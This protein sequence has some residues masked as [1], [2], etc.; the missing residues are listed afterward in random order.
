L[1]ADKLRAFA[2]IAVTLSA[3]LILAACSKG[4]HA[5]PKSSPEPGLSRIAA[6]QEPVKLERDMMGTKV[7]IQVSGVPREQALPAINRAFEKIAELESWAHPKHKDS[8]VWNITES[9]GKKPVAVHPGIMEILQTA[10]QVSEASGGAFDITFAAAGR[11]WD[12]KHPDAVPPDPQLLAQAVRKVDYRKLKLDEQH[13]TA[14]LTEEGMEIGLGAIAK[15]WAAD[16]AADSLKAEGFRSGIVDAGGDMVV[17]GGKGQKPWTVEINHPRKPH[18][19]LYAT[20]RPERP[21]AIVTSGD[22]ERY[23]IKNDIRYHHILDPKTGDSARLCQSVTV[24][25][26]NGML[27]DAL[28]TAVFVMG[29]EKGLAMLAQLYPG[30][31][32]LVI[33]SKGAESVSSDFVSMTNLVRNTMER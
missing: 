24:V 9:A 14:F 8:D 31:A 10:R 27:A 26:P 12:L 17:W 3:F 30:Y 4:R 7:G 11:L 19:S 29:P 20:M 5:F 2:L 25:G 22:Y 23:V 13:G 28:A 21:M 1:R 15:G 33:D 6:G 32:A 18:G 16:R